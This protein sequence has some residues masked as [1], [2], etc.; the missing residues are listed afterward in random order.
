MKKFRQ[1]YYIKLKFQI[2]V[3]QTPHHHVEKKVDYLYL[4]KIFQ[5]FFNIILKQRKLLLK[6]E[7]FN[8]EIIIGASRPL[9]FFFKLKKYINR[10]LL[11]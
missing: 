11:N 8:I 2:S 5:N 3:N 9:K 1:K 4:E 6:R 7:S 10:V